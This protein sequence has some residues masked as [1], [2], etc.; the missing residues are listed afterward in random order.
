MKHK[1]PVKAEMQWRDRTTTE[2]YRWQ[3]E[4]N[5]GKVFILHDG[6]PYANGN[7]HMGE[8]EDM[9]SGGGDVCEVLINMHLYVLGHS[10][11]KLLKDFINRYKAIKGHRVKFVAPRLRCFIGSDTRYLDTYPDGIVTVFP[12]N[13]KH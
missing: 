5:D 13:T 10:L 4:N 6:P 8:Q 3:W 11:N 7:L 2:L 12:S 1:D 9:V